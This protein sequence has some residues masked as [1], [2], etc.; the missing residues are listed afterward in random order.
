M[1]ELLKGHLAASLEPALTAGKEENA[2]G[3]LGLLRQGENLLREGSHRL[4]FPGLIGF[5]HA[6]DGL[7]K[8]VHGH[9]L[10]LGE[11]VQEL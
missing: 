2:A 1:G 11:L 6:L 10:E 5:F 7:P 3:E 8:V 4:H 9:I